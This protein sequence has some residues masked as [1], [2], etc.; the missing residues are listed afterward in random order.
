M[1]FNKAFS[2]LPPIL[3]QYQPDVV[4]LQEIDT[5]EENLKKLED[6]G[7]RLADYANCFIEFG[8]IWG[9]ATYY[10]QKKFEFVNSKPIPLINGLYEKIK[11][12]SRLFRNRGLRR[13]ILKTNLKMKST[14]K[15]ITV[16]NL[17]L[18]AVSLN[19]LRLKQLKMI[20]FDDFEQKGSIIITGDF[21]FPIER[22]KLEKAM[23]R[24]QL[25]EA[26]NKLFYTLRFPSNP[27]SYSFGFIYRLFYKFIKRFWSDEAKLDYIFYRGLKNIKTKRLDYSFSDHFPIIARFEM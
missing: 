4:C 2:Q 7:Y 23:N 6:L 16:Y 9:I 3:K 19:N 13:T 12:V 20:D 27:A 5:K 22:K 24:Y 26:T 21:N 8:K 10:N 17:H 1:F 15:K 14:G 18:S 25:K 11:L